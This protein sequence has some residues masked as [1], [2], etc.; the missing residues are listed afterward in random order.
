M[1]FFL[2]L[3]LSI[4]SVAILHRI[5]INSKLGDD[6]KEKWFF[7]LSLYFVLTSVIVLFLVI[8]GLYSFWNFMLIF[9]C[10]LMIFFLINAKY[11]WIH[12]SIKFQGT[13]I[14]KKD[15]NVQ[16]LLFA[17]LVVS[18]LLLYALF[19]TEYIIGGRD[20]GVYVSE[21][22]LIS[23]TG[24]LQYEDQFISE[25][26][27]RLN[28]VI[29]LGYPGFY[30]ALNRG[31][32]D[33]PGQ[34]VPQFLP[35]F[36]SVLALAY[37]LFGFDGLFRLNAILG[38]LA[39]LSIYFFTRRLFG[40]KTAILASFLVLLNPSEIWNARITQTELLSQFLFFNSLNHFVLA[41]SRNQPIQLLISGFVL[42][43]GCFNRVDSHLFGLGVFAFLIY[44]ALF[45]KTKIKTYANFASS[46]ALISSASILYG[47][48]YSKPYFHD[49]WKMGALSKLLAAN[50]GLLFASILA[51]G[52]ALLI[53][54]RKRTLIPYRK[55]VN[56]WSWVLICLLFALF[57]FSY[58]IRPHLL[59]PV[60][61]VGSDQYFKHFAMREFA[62]YVPVVAIL[63]AFA[64][65]FALLKKK[66]LQLT[67]LFVVIS[68]GSIVGYI[69]DPSITPDHLWASRRWITVSIP[70]MLIFTSIS[71]TSLFLDKKI[72]KS[73]MKQ[74]SKCG[75][76]AIL[77]FLFAFSG[78]Q[79]KP[80]LYRTM[81]KDYAGQ[82]E[83]LA[84]VF[85]EN[86]VILSPNSRISTPLRFVF[87]KK[88]YVVTNEV[89]ESQLLDF[90]KSTSQ[91]VYS[92]N[93]SPSIESGISTERYYFQF[94][95]GKY[96]D[97][98]R[99]AYPQ[100]TY[101]RDFDLMV[102]E[103]SA[104]GNNT[105]HQ[106]RL[107]NEFSTKIGQKVSPDGFVSDGKE[108]FL[109]FG[110]YIDLKAGQYN[111]TFKGVLEKNETDM[112]ELGFVDVTSNRGKNVIKRLPLTEDLDSVHFS[113]EQDIEDFEFR[114]YLN[115]GVI[116][117]IENVILEKIEQT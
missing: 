76:L 70:S 116:Y 68:L 28:K 83:Q 14:S 57:I 6:R 50:A 13:R 65:L 91:K 73:K 84:A 7:S 96:V 79:S 88:A 39:V 36:P 69:Y 86:S 3:I 78:Y 1:K 100:G 44:L 93:W 80:F 94:I 64:G 98:T 46:Y 34:L 85:P 112:D 92:I 54:T 59:D 16:N 74:V 101:D 56:L 51:A 63:L 33:N 95:H 62:W 77:F 52:I 75:F 19:P 111:V 15:F 89:D 17:V 105:S 4:I 58:F 11:K 40:E 113:L 41:F 71:L 99:G 5:A 24:G 104:Q 26:Y 72:H 31:L 61:E 81:L 107:Q 21:A 32:S 97:K 47:F 27:D 37:D 109:L 42:G 106:F 43:L 55:V 18:A 8:C 102:L 29:N 20:Q 12:L 60:Y 23:E 53:R 49:L 90:L 38:V 2:F 66:S 110:P 114:I 115:D 45:N 48:V 108:G 22:V 103:L 87:N 117:R 10:L 82:F 35:L 30:S 9:T 25:N 67:G